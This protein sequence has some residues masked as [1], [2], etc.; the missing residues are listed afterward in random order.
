MKYDFRSISESALANSRA[1]IETWLPG[2]N[3]SGTEYTVK[4]P[5]RPDNKA[6]SFKIN[7]SS[8]AWCDFA[9]GDKGGDLIDL[10]VYINGC[11]KK[12]A[13]EEL[14]KI[15]GVQPITPRPASKPEE[16]FMQVIPVPD[17][18]P[19]LPDKK[20]VGSNMYTPI[21]NS[22]AYRTSAGQLIGYVIRYERDGKKE[23]PF[24]TLFRSDSGELKWMTK[25]PPR[26]LPLFNL[27]LL[28]DNPEAVV[29]IVEGEKC[30][31]VLQEIIPNKTRYIATTWVG[32]CNGI[33][34]ADFSPIIKRKC[35][36]WPDFDLQKNKTTEQQPGYVAMMEISRKLKNCKIIYPVSGKPDGWDVADAIQSDGWGWVQI[37]KFIKENIKPV[38]K[39][40]E[41]PDFPPDNPVAP[42][43]HPEPVGDN[44]TPA[45]RSQLPFRI[46]G[47][48]NDYYYFIGDGSGQI[49]PIKGSLIN[50]A[51]L[52]TLAPE[53]YWERSSFQSDKGVS[54]N[55]VA[56][57]I[58][59]ESHK[60]G[61]FEPSRV[62]G[63]GA[64]FDKGRVVLHLGDH[65]LADNINRE[66]NQFPSRFIYNS[67]PPL[68]FS[69]AE[70]LSKHNANKLRDISGALLWEKP[71]NAIYFA[72]WC[73][74]ATICGAMNTRP[75]IWLTGGTGS[76]KTYIFE[77][78]VQKILGEFKFHAQS[79]TT[80]AGIRQKL[81]S[82]ALPVIIDEFESEDLRDKAR[83]GGILELTRQSFS[84]SGAV[85]VK[86]G[87]SGKPQEFNIRSCFMM[88]SIVVGID[89]QAD[90]NR[91]SVL[92]LRDP[93]FI[94]GHKKDT[95]FEA[96]QQSI[97][98]TITDE[99]AASFRARAYKMIPIIRKNT[100]IF[101]TAISRHLGNQRAGDQAGPMLAGA[102][103]LSSDSLITPEKAKEFIEAQDWSEKTDIIGER[104]ELKCLYKIMY[105]VIRDERSEIGISEALIK[106]REILH[107]GL[108]AD[109]MDAAGDDKLNNLLKRHGIRYEPQ[110]DIIYI[111]PAHPAIKEF[112]EKTPWEKGAGRML[113]RV[114]GAAYTTKRFSGIQT[115]AIGIPWAEIFTE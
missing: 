42:E 43:L 18:S 91:I 107:S 77:N 46:L 7:I 40:P 12:T 28:H 94:L 97:I 115:K 49:K 86:G 71:I 104:D 85:I 30:A 19:P 33:P 67:L 101:A 31:A 36:L 61:I 22:W 38:N 68:E 16:L 48:N 72:G 58:I 76:G 113:L 79:K 54:W 111:A 11:D 37:K 44:T 57:F 73:V 108:T 88:A 8:G 32:G 109:P 92:G 5:T 1:L 59:Q 112:L 35:I 103:S 102:Y 114:K 90:A 52:R 51:E 83:I 81:N 17:E 96:L 80:E 50:R 74:I 39:N 87:Q 45:A 62:R 6:G 10:Y 78:I 110:E 55:A 15:T 29:I 47:H 75:H 65:L 4:N 60:K 82:D 13:A 106:L 70:P 100:E 64:W 9:T 34:N 3:L 93:F 84:Q 56:D 53:Q 24:M 14:M 98:E 23:T 69:T 89:M 20:Y 41:N 26:P 2:G 21:Q 66:L 99:W 95:H 105:S 25:R 27:D 63:R